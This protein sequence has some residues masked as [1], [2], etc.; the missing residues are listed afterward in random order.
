M[1]LKQLAKRLVKCNG[2]TAEEEEEILKRRQRDI[3]LYGYLGAF[4]R[5]R[6]SYEKYEWQ[7]KNNRLGGKW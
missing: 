2:R 3:N 1:S 4:R 7:R 5:D 6:M